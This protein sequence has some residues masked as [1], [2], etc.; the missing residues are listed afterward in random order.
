MI[1]DA[2]V[3]KGHEL[4]RLHRVRASIGVLLRCWPCGLHPESQPESH[5][6]RGSVA[7]RGAGATGCDCGAG[8]V[9]GQPPTNPRL[10]WPAY[11]LIGLDSS[12]GCRKS[13][14]RPLTLSRFRQRSRDTTF[15]GTGQARSP[16]RPAS[17]SYK[18][19]AERRA[20]PA[21][22][23]AGISPTV[24]YRFCEGGASLSQRRQTSSRAAGAQFDTHVWHPRSVSEQL[25]SARTTTTVSVQW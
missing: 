14:A 2:V 13:L 17:R 21:A 8:A 7:R 20:S 11:H 9:T 24:A 5:Q 15:G 23:K 6:R 1:T 19:P 25:S 4:N 10:A 3:L 16:V 22:R 12:A 18:A